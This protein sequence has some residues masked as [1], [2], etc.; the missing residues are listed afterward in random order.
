MLHCGH[1]W[2]MEARYVRTH[3]SFKS[4]PVHS[5]ECQE[6][7]IDTHKASPGDADVASLEEG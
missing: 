7:A 4:K 5:I 6:F 3:L 2:L 1:A